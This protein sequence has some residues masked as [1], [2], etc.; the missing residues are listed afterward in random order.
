MAHI[1]PDCNYYQVNLHAQS[2][3]SILFIYFYSYQNNIS[4][5]KIRGLG[6]G[7]SDSSKKKMGGSDNADYGCQHY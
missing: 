1:L 2:I 3:L 7:V 6:E 5:L 4:N